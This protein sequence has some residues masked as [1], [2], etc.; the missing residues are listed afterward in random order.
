M[1][2][3]FCVLL[4]IMA[5]LCTACYYADA[6]KQID[7]KDIIS[8]TALLYTELSDFLNEE[9]ISTYKMAQYIYPLF[10]GVPDSINTLHLIIAD[11]DLETIQ[12]YLA[13]A[14]RQTNRSIHNIN[15]LN[16]CVCIGEYQRLSQ[17][18]ELC[19]SVFTEEYWTELN[20]TSWSVPQFVEINQKLYF[21]DISKGSI[22]GY[23]PT[24]YPDT[25]EVVCRTDTEICFKVIGHYKS[26][27]VES[28]YAIE[29]RRFPIKLVLEDDGWRFSLFSD[30]ALDD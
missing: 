6:D 3:Y 26:S 9:Q 5:M 25:Y 12:D 10:N 15:G 21:V 8:E 22:V 29:T 14:E 18:K 11:A 17:F 13:D 23:N 7:D 27:T 20:D 30:A 4:M 28:E 2:T 19:L 1:K 24:E 16:Y